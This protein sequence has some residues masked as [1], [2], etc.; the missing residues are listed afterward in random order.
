MFTWWFTCSPEIWLREEKR[1]VPVWNLLVQMVIFLNLPHMFLLCIPEVFELVFL[2]LVPQLWA[3]PHPPPALVEMQ[4]VFG[5]VYPLLMLLVV[6]QVGYL[7]V[8]P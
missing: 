8:L 5:Q 3:H 1:F 6:I 2:V 4:S 7:L